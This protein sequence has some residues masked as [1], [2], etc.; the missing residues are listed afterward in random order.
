MRIDRWGGIN[1]APPTPL[2]FAIPVCFFHPSSPTTVRLVVSSRRL[3]KAAEAIREVVAS[4]IVTEIRDPR[5]RDV[6]VVGVEVTPDMREAK[7]FVSV[8][9][10]DAKQKLSV[11][12]L[13]N[14]AG[15]LQSKIANRID[16]RYTPK[17]TFVL[18]KGLKNAAAVG[19]ILLRI[20]REREEAEALRRPVA[21]AD[22][23][24]GECNDPS[25]TDDASD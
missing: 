3:L 19:E 10:D 1:A 20:Q 2:S 11:R 22:D 21:D 23:D 12:G 4:A 17:L 5:I 14:S 16:T 13:Q 24:A 15:F 9:G 18:D 6:T 8:M 25:K 7:V